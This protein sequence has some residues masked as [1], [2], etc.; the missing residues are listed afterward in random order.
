[1]SMT[2]TGIKLTIQQ[3]D[4]VRDWRI[5]TNTKYS[6]MAKLVQARLS[7]GQTFAESTLKHAL[8]G[9]GRLRP[10]VYRELMRLVK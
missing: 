6:V 8:D 1:M 9:T 2:A 5:R 4:R 7:D 3:S 10:D